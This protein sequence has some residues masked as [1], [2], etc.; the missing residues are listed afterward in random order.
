MAHFV[1]NKTLMDYL[2][3]SGFK[4]HT[5]SAKPLLDAF[6]LWTRGEERVAV[7]EYEEGENRF[8]ITVCRTEAASEVWVEDQK[9]VLEA[10]NEI[11]G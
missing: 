5:L 4:E 10:L 2:T 8:L 3:N 1:P 7:G 9:K 6:K 11:F